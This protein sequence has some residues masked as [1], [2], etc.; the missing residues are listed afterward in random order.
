MPG[1]MVDV[2]CLNIKN[3]MPKE[4]VW[5]RFIEQLSFAEQCA[6]KEQSQL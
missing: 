5:N 2:L 6:L 3:N 4:Y 1:S